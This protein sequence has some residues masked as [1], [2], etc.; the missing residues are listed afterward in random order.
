MVRKSNKE[1]KF[2]HI[3]STFFTLLIYVIKII[4]IYDT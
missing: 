1:Q 2:L 3:T 4:K